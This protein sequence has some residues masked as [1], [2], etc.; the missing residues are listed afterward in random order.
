MFDPSQIK[1]TEVNS[2]Y[3]NDNYNEG[4][5]YEKLSKLYLQVGCPSEAAEAH[6]LAEAEWEQEM[7]KEISDFWSERKEWEDMPAWF[8]F[9]P[10]F[11]LKSDSVL[12]YPETFASLDYISLF[13]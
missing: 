9:S 8:R 1:L 7:D 3:D 13:W 5:V 11:R 4:V 2:M 6:T 12:F 10:E